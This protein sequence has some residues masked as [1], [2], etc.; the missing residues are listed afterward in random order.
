MALD[1]GMVKFTGFHPDRHYNPMKPTKYGFKIY[2]LAESSSGYVLQY[3]IAI[4]SYA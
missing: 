3:Q 2:I 4:R 1:E